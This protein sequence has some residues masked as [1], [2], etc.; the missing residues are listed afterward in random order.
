MRFM[1]LCKANRESEAGGM[2]SA[3][4]VSEMGDFN[5]EM[6]KAG[7]LLA[8]EGLQPSS[9]GVRITYDGK[10]RIVVDG[11]FAETQEL[12]AGFWVIQVASRDEAMS[13]AL[14]IPFADGETVELRQILELEDF[15]A[16]VV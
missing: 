16:D 3:E 8:G 14:R 10:R 6:V 15:P 9:K 13:W 11:P 2:P 5:D 7:V 4:H 12:I 1:L